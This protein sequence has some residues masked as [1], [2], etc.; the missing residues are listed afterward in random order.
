M[1]RTNPDLWQHVKD[2]ITERNLVGTAS[3]QWSARKAQLAVKMYKS[4]G[5]G[6]IG[7]KSKSNSLVKWTEQDWT[8]KSGLPSSVTGERYLPRKAIEALTPKEYNRTSKI[9]RKSKKQYSKQP[10]DIAKKVKKYRK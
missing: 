1:I 5:G 9:K 2:Y 10:E 7:S 6:Y 8:T 4:L 3:N